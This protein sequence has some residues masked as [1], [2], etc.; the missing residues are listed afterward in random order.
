MKRTVQKA[1][2]G[3]LAVT[4]LHR[5]LAPWTAGRGAI[6]TMHRVRPARAEAF[7][8]NA[9]L[10]IT[11]DFL[12]RLL[13]WFR[14]QG[15]DIVTLDDA[16]AR[17][18]APPRR[19]RFVVL[20]LD[21]G[22]RDNL[23]FALPVFKRHLAPFTVFVAS[24]FPDRDANPWWMTLDAVIAGSD[25]VALLG[26]APVTIPTRTTAEKYSAFSTL[27][28][29]VESLP[30]DSQR[31]VMDDFAAR[32]G[33]DVR[34]LLDDAFMTWDE[35]RKL[36]VEPLATIGGHTVNHPALGRLPEDR[37]REEVV[38]GADRLQ[39]EL[40]RRPR[41]FAYPYGYPG[42]VG[43]RD[44]RLLAA[45]GFTTAVRTTPG[46][47]TEASAAAPTALPRIPLNGHFQRV[48]DVE[49]LLSGAPFAASVIRDRLSGS[50]R[51]APAPASASSG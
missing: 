30:E 7:Q 5:M 6:L 18:V 37:A 23:E 38:T 4:Q 31:A 34:A 16:L 36:A 47:L 26:A 33:I 12:D 9:H 43:E 8:P 44:Y 1:V 11:P 14:R 2:L 45:L 27:A 13:G 51:A 28:A 3:T 22:Y 24:G 32:H 42:K 10:E 17:L 20:T 29:R 48:R 40:G 35:L 39:A 41:H 25:S 21:D 49:V 19:G 15:I 46:T 50:R